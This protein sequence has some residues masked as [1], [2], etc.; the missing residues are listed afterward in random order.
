MQ[1]WLNKYSLGHLHASAELSDACL[2]YWQIIGVSPVWFP[3]PYCSTAPGLNAIARH[4]L[5]QE[6]MVPPSWL[7]LLQEQQ[8]RTEVSAPATPLNPS[9]QH[10]VTF[11]GCRMQPPYFLMEELGILS[12]EAVNSLQFPG[13]TLVHK[14]K[15][16]FS[17]ILVNCVIFCYAFCRA[18]RCCVHTDTDTMANVNFSSSPSEAAH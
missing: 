3:L 2:Y 13:I 17:H 7:S 14:H 11:I 6:Q 12:C 9:L 8:K 10:S 18:H 16:S 1:S 5:L 15:N 4:W